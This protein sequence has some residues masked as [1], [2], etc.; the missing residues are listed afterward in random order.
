MLLWTAKRRP[1]TFS[2]CSLISSNDM[3]SHVFAKTS[4]YRSYGQPRTTLPDAS[5]YLTWSATDWT[6][7]CSSPTHMVSHRLHHGASTVRKTAWVDSHEEQVHHDGQVPETTPRT[8]SPRR[9]RR[10]PVPRRL[11][12]SL[13]LLIPEL[14]IFGC[15]E[16]QCKQ[17]SL[18]P[19]N[20]DLILY[21]RLP[22]LL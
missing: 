13:S 2:E 9:H 11:R 7:G 16:S 8:S 18:K 21:K 1:G 5:H 15:A 4:L 17:T 20:P 6:S 3:L 14:N 22:T 12:H 10:S 19:L